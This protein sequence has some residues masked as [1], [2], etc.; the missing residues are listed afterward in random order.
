MLTSIGF[1]LINRQHSG[2]KR[3]CVFVIGVYLCEECIFV[4]SV[5]LFEECICV[6]SVFV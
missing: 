5:Y 3:A 1:R 2:V 6:K 4:K